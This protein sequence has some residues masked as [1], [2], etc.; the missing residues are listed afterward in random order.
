MLLQSA[1]DLWRIV[2]IGVLTY[3]A[4]IAILRLSGKRTLAKMNAFDLIVTVALGSTLA[5]ILLSRDV[6]LLEGLTALILLVVLQ[7][8]ASW[9]SVRSRPVRRLLKSQPTILLR[10]GRMLPNALREQRVTAGEV[11]QAIRSQGIGSLDAVSAV[12]LET[13]GSFSVVPAS[14][15]GDLSALNGIDQT[16]ADA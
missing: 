9:L 10:D 5:T 14:Q 11:R 15:A 16:A 1:S 12:T 7:L 2:I 3:P 6:A 8:G 4:L 13:D